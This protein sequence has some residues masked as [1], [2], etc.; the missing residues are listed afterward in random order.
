VPDRGRAWGATYVVAGVIALAL[1]ALCAPAAGAAA[2]RFLLPP[3]ADPSTRTSANAV[4]VDAYGRV[5]VAGDVSVGGVWRFAVLRLRADL[6]P[7]PAFG[8]GGWW[9]YAPPGGAALG[10]QGLALQPDGKVLVAGGLAGPTARYASVTRV[11][12]DGTTDQAFGTAGTAAVLPRG[13]DQGL[14]FGVGVQTDGRIVVVGSARQASTHRA[15][16]FATRFGPHGVLDASYGNGGSVLLPRLGLRAGAAWGVQIDARDRAVLGGTAQDVVTTALRTPHAVGRTDLALWSTDGLLAGQRITVGSGTSAETATIMRIAG[17]TTLDLAGG[18]RRSHP[19]G[20]TIT[21]SV[22]RQICARLTRTGSLDP[23][24]NAPLGYNARTFGADSIG[25][26]V[27]LQSDGRAVVAGAGLVPPHLAIVVSR[28][29]A[30]G[31]LDPTFG[32]GDGWEAV[33]GTA[34]N[35]LDA[36]ARDRLVLAGVGGQVT[37]SRLLPGGL[38][39][40]DFGDDGHVTKPAGSPWLV[41]NGV[42]ARSDGYV[43]AGPSVGR[44][45]QA[46][47]V[48]ALPG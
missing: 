24:F 19:S 34:V 4:A 48:L 3:G 32:D 29:R 36:D 38:L 21:E 42:A 7:D 47:S 14:A 10:V 35:A 17:P 22:D 28:Y 2:P 40:D 23:T 13:S 20:A 11:N 18:L 41:A 6:L 15:V 30:D 46:W 16:Q 43:L 33:P 31:T 37:A 1:L 39:D 26:A 12:S 9:L 45:P 5:Y 44:A 27:T 8:A 25:F